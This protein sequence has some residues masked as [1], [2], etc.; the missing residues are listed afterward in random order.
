MII[1]GSKEKIA[2]EYKLVNSTTWGNAKLWLGG[3][4]LGVLE[5]GIYIKGYLIE[6]LNRICSVEDINLNIQGLNK[7]EIYELL[8]TNLDKDDNSSS[9]KYLINLGTFCDDFTVFAFKKEHDIYII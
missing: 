4:P 7:T 5:D 3:N 2:V 8:I 6:G 1:L 9:E